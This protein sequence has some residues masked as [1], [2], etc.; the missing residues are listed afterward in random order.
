MAEFARTTV[1]DAARSALNAFA[2]AAPPAHVLVAI[3][4]QDG[5]VATA[6]SVERALR[7]AAKTFT[8]TMDLRGLDVGY[9]GCDSQELRFIIEGI[10]KAST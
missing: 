10:W 1:P 8:P 3:Q 6:D 7:E 4:R 5:Q 9:V 2:I